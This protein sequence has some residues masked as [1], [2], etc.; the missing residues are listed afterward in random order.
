M[1]PITSGNLVAIKSSGK[2]GVYMVLELVRR[3]A[4]VSIL[5][6][7]VFVFGT[8]EAIAWGFVISSVIDVVIISFPTKR[9]VGYSLIEQI[10]DLWKIFFCSIMMGGGMFPILYLPIPSFI[11]FL[12]QIIVGIMVYIGFCF[13]FDVKPIFELIALA[14]KLLYCNKNVS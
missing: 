12:I 10:K 9:I 4:M 3:L 2:S 13:L 7:G 1:F 6:V 11:I 5:L 14:N 8:V